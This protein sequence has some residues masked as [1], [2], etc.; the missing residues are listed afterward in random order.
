MLQRHQ[1]LKRCVQRERTVS[2]GTKTL[3][4]FGDEYVEMSMM[5][6]FS[7]VSHAE[8]IMIYMIQI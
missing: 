2:P 6:L 8:F 4:S 7:P 5:Y 1:G 3:T